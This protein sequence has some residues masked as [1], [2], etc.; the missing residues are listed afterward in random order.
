VEVEE[1]G[2][3]QLLGIHVTHHKR[4]GHWQTTLWLPKDPY[5]P[6]ITPRLGGLILGRPRTFRSFQ[7]ASEMLVMEITHSISDWAM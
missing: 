6:H 3:E 5:L 4:R 1:T 2:G 7:K